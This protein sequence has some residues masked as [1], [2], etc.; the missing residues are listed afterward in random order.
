MPKRGED[1]V[2]NGQHHIFRVAS[3][4]FVMIA[5]QLLFS[6]CPA[7]AR[8]T[9]AAKN[10]AADVAKF[11]LHYRSHQPL[12][13]DYVLI[14]LDDGR[15]I[16]LRALDDTLFFWGGFS[17]NSGADEIGE[18]AAAHGAVPPAQVMHMLNNP[19]P[20][21]ALQATPATPET[22]Q[23]KL[24][25]FTEDDYGELLAAPGEMLFPDKPK[26]ETRLVMFTWS[27]CS[28]CEKM[29]RYFQTHI[30]HVKF[31]VKFLPI[32]GNPKLDSNAISYLDMAE[33]DEQTKQSTL[34]RLHGASVVLGSRVGKILVPA[35]AWLD[36]QGKAH[37][38][39]LDGATFREVSTSLNG[40][41][42]LP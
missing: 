38:G 41:V 13:K 27:E 15:K 36:P 7:H 30:E 32:A 6:V 3:L 34:A 12:E 25:P 8:D 4:T 37:I 5:G 26:D 31:Q 29:R 17:R 2:K 11:G 23:G 16:I 28:A 24:P 40:G 22:S 20:G 33:A 14:T 35:F 9:G 18:L 21:A 42:P 1:V 10:L 39:N 19:H